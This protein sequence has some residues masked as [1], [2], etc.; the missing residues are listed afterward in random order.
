MHTYIHTYIFH[1]IGDYGTFPK[2]APFTMHA[3]LVN[4]FLQGVSYPVGGSSQFAYNMVPIIEKAG[5]KCFVRS[6]VDEIITEENGTAVGVRIK[7]D[8]NIIKAPVIISNAGLYNTNKLL[9]KEHSQE[10]ML[11]YILILKKN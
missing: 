7:R 8:G 2:D 5:G 4:H 6:E 9:K 1:Y 3:I 11:L 10:V